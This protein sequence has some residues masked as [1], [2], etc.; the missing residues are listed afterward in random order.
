MI[1]YVKQYPVSMKRW[2][3]SFCYTVSSFILA[4]FWLTRIKININ[5][6][7]RGYNSWAPTYIHIVANL[8]IW[9]PRSIADLRFVFSLY[10]KKSTTTTDTSTHTVSESLNKLGIPFSKLDWQ[11][12][13]TMNCYCLWFVYSLQCHLGNLV[14]SQTRLQ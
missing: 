6:F 14:L 3:K 2:L 4:M 13:S 12:K 5:R 8:I 10:L 1:R 7:T 11:M 9:F